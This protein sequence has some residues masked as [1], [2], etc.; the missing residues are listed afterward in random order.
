M[1]V[2]RAV[3]RLVLGPLSE[4]LTS[5]LS[6]AEVVPDFAEHVLEVLNALPALDRRRVFSGYGAAECPRWDH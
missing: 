6:I 4:P 3:A 1:R 5:A 2:L